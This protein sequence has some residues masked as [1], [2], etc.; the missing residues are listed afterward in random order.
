[1]HKLIPYVENITNAPQT[2]T[3]ESGACGKNGSNDSFPYIGYLFNEV[4]FNQ[5]KE[6]INSSLKDKL[7]ELVEQNCKTTKSDLSSYLGKRQGEVIFS[8]TG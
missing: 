5:L 2:E 8:V 4:K 3:I 6:G 1:M 7:K